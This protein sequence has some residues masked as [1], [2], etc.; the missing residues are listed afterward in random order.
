MSQ[1]IV[2]VETVEKFLKL[3]PAGSAKHSKLG[4]L[5]KRPYG[6]IVLSLMEQFRRSWCIKQCRGKEHR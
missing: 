1:L 5:R 3:S 2:G 4:L 6:R